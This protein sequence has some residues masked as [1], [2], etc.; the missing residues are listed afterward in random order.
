[1][2]ILRPLLLLVLSAV[3]LSACGTV[4]QPFRDTAKTRLT[5]LPTPQPS[6]GLVLLPIEVVGSES[7]DVP[8]LH[9]QIIRR[10]HSLEIAAT[11][12]NIRN[13]YR[14]SGTMQSLRG[15]AGRTRLIFTWRLLTARGSEI[16]VT[17]HGVPVPSEKWQAGNQLLMERVATE[18]AY[19]IRDLINGDPANDGDQDAGQSRPLLVTMANVTDS[20][21]GAL[22]LMIAMR[23]ALRRAQ[24]DVVDTSP[25]IPVVSVSTSL[26]R[27]T[28]SED[29][30]VIVWTVRDADGRQRGQMKQQNRV[31]AGKLKFRWGTTAVLAANGAVGDLIDL[32]KR[33]RAADK[34]PNGAGNRAK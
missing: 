28:G 13:R 18:A 27:I 10:L 14:M 17:Q 33:L 29:L 32:L 11:A 12:L 23:R 8:A 19:R 16:S 26:T 34:A 24:V 2:N 7:G 30:V 3:L 9:A 6:A 31:P 5:A 15:E 4:P 21:G 25:G 1:M 22:E 20:N